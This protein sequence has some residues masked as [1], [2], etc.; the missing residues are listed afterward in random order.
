[1]NSHLAY[2]RISSGIHREITGAGNVIEAGHFL[3]PVRETRR[4]PIFSC[5]PSVYQKEELW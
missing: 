1:L 4:A 5:L 2:I 3:K